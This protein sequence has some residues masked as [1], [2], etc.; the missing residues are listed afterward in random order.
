[1]PFGR[2]KRIAGSVPRVADVVI[3]GWTAAGLVTFSSGLRVNVTVN[4]NPANTGTPNRPNVVRD[5][6]LPSGQQSLDR[7][8]DTGA[9]VTN[10]AFTFGNAGRNLI[11]GPDLTNFDLAL[12]KNFLF[13]ETMRL[14][15]R[16][17]AFNATNTPYFGSPNNVLGVLGFG[18]ISSAGRPRNLQFGLKFVF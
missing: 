12:Y 18:Q 1:L 5:W 3:G 6:R 8:F 2:G 16:V 14:Q 7:W 10:A 9:F 4:G 15:F 17:E 11:D 13:T